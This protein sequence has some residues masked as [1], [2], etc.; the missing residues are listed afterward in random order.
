MLRGLNLPD[1]Q[2]FAFIFTQDPLVHSIQLNVRAFVCI[3]SLL[4]QFTLGLT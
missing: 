1:E 3:T 2:S 4:I